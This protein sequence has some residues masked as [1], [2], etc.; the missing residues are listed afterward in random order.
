MFPSSLKDPLSTFE[1]CPHIELTSDREWDP[2]NV[3]MPGSNKSADVDEV[4]TQRFVQQVD[5]NRA[6]ATNRDWLRYESDFV[7]G[8]MG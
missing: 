5:N 6:N 3:P 8:S 4:R 7:L 1:Y 2:H